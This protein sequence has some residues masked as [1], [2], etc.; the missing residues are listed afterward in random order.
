[1]VARMSSMVSSAAL[2]V[3]LIAAVPATAFAAQPKYAQS[4]CQ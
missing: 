2:M 3:T 4:G 1:M